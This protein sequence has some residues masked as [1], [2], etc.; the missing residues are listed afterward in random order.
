W[1]QREPQ[2]FAKPS[3][4]PTF[5]V[6]TRRLERPAAFGGRET[7]SNLPFRA[8]IGDSNLHHQRC[9]IRTFSLPQAYIAADPP[10]R[11]MNRPPGGDWVNPFPEGGLE[12]CTRNCSRSPPSPAAW[13]LAPP[14]RPTP[15]ISTSPAGKRPAGGTTP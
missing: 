1:E 8:R 2:P 7:G 5:T 13:P 6:R 4:P 9:L 12:T 14:P 3:T 11:G 15:S 10:Y